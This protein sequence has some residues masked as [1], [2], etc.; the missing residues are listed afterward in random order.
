MG[1]GEA[2]NYA[3]SAIALKFRSVPVDGK[4]QTHFIA[5]ER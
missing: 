1:L 4:I 3:A 2:T 5:V